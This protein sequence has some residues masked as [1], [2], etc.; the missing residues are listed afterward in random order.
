M[1]NPLDIQDVEFGKAMR[2]YSTGEVDKFL[3]EI[4]KD[5]EVVFRENQEMKERIAGLE[6]QVDAY[7]HMEKA[8]ND[9][10][11]VARNTAEDLKSNAVKE[12][13]FINR[14]AEEEAKRIIEKANKEV[15]RIKGEFDDL[16]KKVLIFRQRY[17]NLLQ[18]QI[19]LLDQ[20]ME[21]LFD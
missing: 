18:S 8:L 6:E 7:R 1:L 11:I 2:G 3:D 19:D 17:K 4:F 5:Y 16:K 14:R 12:S 20:T 13:E 9:T 15:M 21:D 10:L